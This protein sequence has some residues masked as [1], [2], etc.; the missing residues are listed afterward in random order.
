MQGSGGLIAEARW[1]ARG[2]SNGIALTGGFGANSSD[3]CLLSGD[4][5]LTV[6]DRRGLSQ[7]RAPV[8]SL[9]SPQPSRRTSLT[10]RP[11]NNAEPMGF[12]R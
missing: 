4:R 11:T 5:R 6:T 10:L 9:R 1:L 8:G 2:P 12:S 7:G 3:A